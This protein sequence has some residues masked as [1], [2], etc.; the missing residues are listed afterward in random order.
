LYGAQSLFQQAINRVT[1]IHNRK[2]SL[3]K[4][5]VVTS[6]AHRFL[7]QD[8][9]RELKSVDAELLLEKNGKNT[10]PA[11]TLAALQA[12]ASDKDAILI[13]TPADH[14][15]LD[16]IAFT[17][18]I[19]KCIPIADSGAIVTLGILPDRPETGYGY[20]KYKKGNSLE[21]GYSV[22]KFVEKPDA[23]KAQAY[24]DSKEYV[25][26][27]G[28]FVLRASVWLDALNLFRSDILESTRNAWLERAMDPPFIIPDESLFDYIPSESIDYAVM[29]KCSSSDIHVQML[30]LDAGWSDLGSWESIWKVHK[31]DM[32]G[33]A[34]QGKAVMIDTKNS[35]VYSSKRLVAT[36]GVEDLAVVETED[37]ILVAHLSKSEKAK[38]LINEIRELEKKEQTNYT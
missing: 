4:V 35:F 32:N 2:I 10:A 34:S 30:M 24:V 5:I 25:W 13:V 7:V 28:I 29:E 38:I 8:Q 23:E 27:S 15:V 11:L 6:E 26:N 31:R 20:L 21:T 22:V 18:A 37:S 3:K 17:E 33:N 12:E 14:N 16:E 1:R 19:Q 36:V 9:L